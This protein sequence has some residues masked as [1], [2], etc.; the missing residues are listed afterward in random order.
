MQAKYVLL[1]GDLSSDSQYESVHNSLFSGT[2]PSNTQVLGTREVELVSNNT[3]E[4]Q[5]FDSSDIYWLNGIGERAFY[6]EHTKMVIDGKVSS[7]GSHIFSYD[8]SNHTI[9]F[10]YVPTVNIKVVGVCLENGMPIAI[11]NNWNTEVSSQTLKLAVDKSYK[12]AD[13]ESKFTSQK[14]T[15]A[16]MYSVIPGMSYFGAAESVNLQ[17]NKIKLYDGP[18]V[19]IKSGNTASVNV[20]Y[21]L[22]D[23]IFNYD[24]MSA[25]VLVVFYYHQPTQRLVIEHRFLNGNPLP[26]TKWQEE[27]KLSPVTDSLHN[28]P[29]SYSYYEAKAK[30]DYPFVKY[31]LNNGQEEQEYDTVFVSYDET[32]SEQKLVFYYMDGILYVPTPD[33]TDYAN[34]PDG[35]RKAGYF[36]SSDVPNQLMA[37]KAK[38]T[39]Y[40]V[41][42]QSGSLEFNFGYT[43]MN[44]YD[45]TN[46]QPTV[47]FSIP[48]DVYYNGKLYKGGQES[49]V[50]T[51][52]EMQNYVSEMTEEKIVWNIKIEGISVPVWVQEK[53]NDDYVIKANVEFNYHNDSFSSTRKGGAELKVR[54]VGQVYDFTVTNLHE[55]D[56]IWKTSLLSNASEYKANIFP[57]GQGNEQQNAKYNNGIMKGTKFYFSVN[58]KGEEN[59]KIV[60]T[61]S[62]Y[63]IPKEG[64]A[65]VKVDL[66]QNGKKLDTTITR[67]TSVTDANRTL[68]EYQRERTVGLGIYSNEYK[69]PRPS[70]GTYYQVEVG[71]ELRTPFLGYVANGTLPNFYGE[72][73]NWATLATNS[74]ID[75]NSLYKKV[76]HWYGDYTIPN[77]VTYRDS[78]GNALSNEGS[79]TVYFSI[80]TASASGADY[81]GYNLPSPEGDG[82][83]TQ[84]DVENAATS[85]YLPRTVASQYG[86]LNDGWKIG[87]GATATVPVAIYG[88]LATTQNYDTTGTH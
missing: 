59:S 32:L 63:Y 19:D 85:Y 57:I 2:A 72:G 42:D 77:N 68:E 26:I 83:Q 50:F 53:I 49:I 47:T 40:W 31:N 1:K 79:L 80:K 67:L 6:Y 13:Y 35:Y 70:L 81:L 64:G 61:P 23:S 48:F 17:T 88:R 34:N 52:Q 21:D 7:D 58:T 12:E 27:I 29:T 16:N 30:N 66:Y 82:V 60:I 15:N 20:T 71:K 10:Y 28:P 44:D 22:Y 65:P 24:Y 76:S 78:A 46:Y 18:T 73:N 45:S 39:Y 41:L 51:P 86:V 75:Q 14:Y 5:F 25:D 43:N 36:R 87:S 84:W 54:V 38:D 55:G 33:T 74:G 62:F 4:R 8:G 69:N 11:D 37:N 9:T 3:S 56:K